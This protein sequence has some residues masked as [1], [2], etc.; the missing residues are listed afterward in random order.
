M[1]AGLGTL[2][3]EF[4]SS[5]VISLFLFL[6]FFL[7]SLL[8]LVLGLSIS[9]G[10]W[11]LTVDEYYVA[12]VR[13]I[14][15]TV[16]DALEKDPNRRF[17]YAEMAFFSR[18]WEEQ[19]PEKKESVR[20]L[21]K[22]KQLEF[23]NGG[24]CMHDEASPLYS[25]MVD[26]T[27]RGHQFILKEF[28]PDAAPRVTWQI[29][30][31]GHSSTQAWLLSAQAGMPALFW[32]R[33][34]YDDR[35]HLRNTSNMEF[36]WRGSQ[37]LGKSV[38][39]FASVIWGTYGNGPYACPLDF[40][41][42]DDPTKF[43]QDNPE[44]YGYN[45]E[46]FVDLVVEKAHAQARDFPNGEHV[47]WACGM[48]FNFKNADTWFH[49]LDKLMHYVNQDERVNMIYS[50]PG[51]YVSHKNQAQRRNPNISRPLMVRPGDIMPLHEHPHSYWTGYF[52][53]RVA[54]KRLFRYSSAL[55]QAAR[56]I[57]S[58]SSLAS[59]PVAAQ[60][61]AP[62]VGDS[63]TDSFEGALAVAA[64][65][66]GVSGTAKQ[67]VNN[68]YAQRIT[69]AIP[70]VE[71]GMSMGIGRLMSGRQA[72]DQQEELEQ[73]ISWEFCTRLN[74]SICE[75]SASE[76]QKSFSVA[77][78]NSRGTPA[79]AYTFRVPVKNVDGD[80][81]NVL[82]PDGSSLA[83][84]LVELD[85]RTLEL[86]K[87]YLNWF[88]MDKATREK[89]FEK[90]SN[91]ATHTLVFQNDIP[92]VGFSVFTVTKQHEASAA[93]PQHTSSLLR[94]AA[95]AP[96]LRE[97]DNGKYRIAL[98][99]DT[100]ALRSITNLETNFTCKLF[101]QWGWY[102]SSTG[103]CTA[104]GCDQDA[105]SGAYMFRPESSTFHFPGP[106]AK[107]QTHVISGE[108]TTEIRQIVS[109]WVSHV[110][111]LD[112]H[113][114]YVE[115][116]YTVGPIPTHNEWLDSPNRT[117]QLGKELAVRYSSCISDSDGQF[118][119]DSNGL[120]MMERHRD[121]RPSWH[122]QTFSWLDEPVASNYYP[123]NSMIGLRSK[124]SAQ[125][126]VVVTDSTQGGTS[127]HDGELEL[128]VHRR[129]LHDDNKGVVEPLNETM[130][131]CNG[132][133]ESDA[134]CYCHGLTVRGVH[135]LVLDSADQNSGVA[136]GDVRA[137]M[138]DQQF[139]PSLMFSKGQAQPQIWTS[140]SGDLPA[141]VHLMTLSA[142]YAA[143][144]DGGL[145]V[146]FQHVYA[147]DEDPELSKPV[148]IFLDQVFKSVRVTR[149]KELTLTGNKPVESRLAYTWSMEDEGLKTGK[150]AQI[151]FNSETFALTLQP[152]EIR[153]FVLYMETKR[154][155]NLF[156]ELQQQEL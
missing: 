133:P 78:W 1:S 84:Q 150:Y 75:V 11:L 146:R 61:H 149:A 27:T 138:L 62:R 81:W 144:M 33:M 129:V 13:Y 51:D 29:D 40:E 154:E 108:L 21:V 79:Q 110:I 82:G 86:P 90:L 135:K 64:H 95:T 67:A 9:L 47:M 89:A 113:A 60:Q 124:Q 134:T 22:N 12:Q 10:R 114:P 71:Q 45:V 3:A 39:T 24:W 23:I 30:P 147:K 101:I 120:E 131:G 139:R 92:A 111:R 41:F 155:E 18:W 93:I 151:P 25:E 16:T 148:T 115:I 8:L 57:D 19:T 68:D 100:Q 118:F 53:S 117:E 140:L 49:N 31:F 66:D 136:S 87:L 46:K 20:R 99:P 123:I 85:H 77:A 69:A 88:G 122:P 97:F 128:M 55:L 156:E 127:L 103:G 126:F 14:L 107:M 58:L 137:I 121:R 83:H 37:S 98:D 91:G 5:N 130:C 36:V 28:G 74:I 42:Y 76:G 96:P 50:T 63:W 17:S 141:N 152:M 6:F 70:Q 15:D 59:P 52:S 143:R 105:D 4:G 35:K 44:R 104:A 116:E 125:R 32:W 54:F 80:S 132:P 145:L 26:Q 109:P 106:K 56:Q 38:D 153:T 142:N 2:V 65:H 112:R 48:D 72:K 43:V 119:T 102:Q 34:D 94:K 73:Q 7:F